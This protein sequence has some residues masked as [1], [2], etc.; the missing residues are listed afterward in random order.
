MARRRRGRPLDGV[1]LLDKP[2]GLSANQALQRARR[3]FEAAKAGHT[4]TL[5]PM[6]T[7]LLPVCFGEATKFSAFL[8]DADKRYRARVKLGISTDTGD[9]EGKV[10]GTADVPNLTAS[11]LE[12]VLARFR[13]EIEQVP[14]MYSALKHQ[15]RPLYELAREGREI[16]RTPRQVTLHDITLLT[17]DAE[18]GEF[19]LDITCSKGTYIRTLAMDIGSV[20]ACGAHLTM[21]HRLQTGPFDASHMHGLEALEA[22]D[23]RDGCLMPV[24]VLL[25]H[26]PRLSIDAD[27]AARLQMG[28]KIKSDTNA[29]ESD[30]V[31]RVYC[32]DALLGLVTVIASGV[33]APRRMLF[34]ASA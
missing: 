15:G 4:G 25:A 19:E 18:Q 5:D 3:V 7:G 2:K 22:N 32:D 28:Q 21:L 1:L 14:P 23:D 10:I 29:L 24:D 26:L 8:L 6:A 17:L 13:G 33:I 31:A 9:A 16:K 30:T 27:L 20:L 34:N 12:T 11:H